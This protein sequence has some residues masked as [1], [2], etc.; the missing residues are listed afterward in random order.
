M[1]MAEGS[2]RK[3]EIFLAKHSMQKFEGWKKY[4]ALRGRQK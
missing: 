1:N 3:K 2:Y 4:L